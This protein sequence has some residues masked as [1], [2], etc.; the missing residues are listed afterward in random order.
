[1]ETLF[2]VFIVEEKKSADLCTD[3]I[4]KFHLYKTKN[5][6]LDL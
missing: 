1:M 5:N 2:Q 4:Y 6:I 3:Y